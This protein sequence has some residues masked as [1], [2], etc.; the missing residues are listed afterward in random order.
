MN[1]LATLEI[2]STAAHHTL[3]MQAKSSKLI[4]LPVSNIKAKLH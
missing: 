4:A 2:G 3:L 1:P